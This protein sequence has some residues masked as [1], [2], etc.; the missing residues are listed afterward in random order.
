MGGID[1]LGGN[2]KLTNNSKQDGTEKLKLILRRRPE[3]IISFILF[4]ILAA[5]EVYSYL[6]V[7]FLQFETWVKLSLL[8]LI[9]AMTTSIY[10]SISESFSN[11]ESSD[12]LKTE[13][14]NLQ[15]AVEKT[16][17]QFLSTSRYVIDELIARYSRDELVGFIIKCTEKL[18]K[19]ETIHHSIYKLYREHGLLELADEPR[20]SNLKVIFKNEGEMEGNQIRLKCIQDYRATNEAKEESGKKKRANRN[21]LVDFT[22]LDMKNLD[23]TKISTDIFKYINATLKIT[24]SFPIYGL[25]YKNKELVPYILPEKDFDYENIRRKGD[26]ETKSK[27]KLYGVYK[28]SKQADCTVLSLGLY[29][30]VEIPPKECIDFHIETA[31]PAPNFYLLSYEFISW[32]DG[33]DFELLFGDE[34]ECDLSYVLPG[35]PP[36]HI[37]KKELKYNGWIMPHSSISGTWKKKNM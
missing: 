9:F 18:N 5:L 19:F 11:K 28:V 31:G 35:A 4:V 32:T 14:S 34:F 23:E 30:D 36:S 24:A 21:G 25:E 6:F 27:P 37:T 13:F 12:A 15:V 22:S 2:V 1:D 7:E 17:T 29:L 16:R 33:I 3:A 20:K 26:T 8:L 10:H